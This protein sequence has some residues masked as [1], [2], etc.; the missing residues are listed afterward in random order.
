MLSIRRTIS[1]VACA[2]AIL[3]SVGV[4]LVFNLNAKSISVKTTLQ[5]L[6][7]EAEVISEY[8]LERHN[9]ISKNVTFLAKT[10]IA[11]HLLD[12]QNSPSQGQPQTGG[13]VL[14]QAHWRDDTADLFRTMI[15]VSPEYTQVRLIGT[16]NGGRE[17]VRVDRTSDG[18]IKRIPDVEL[19]DKSAEEYYLQIS[20]YDWSGLDPKKSKVLFSRVTFNRENGVKSYPLSYVVRAMHPVFDEADSL[21]GF[22]VINIDY[23][24]LLKS[25]FGG[26][27]RAAN[28]AVLN[29]QGDYIVLMAEGYVSELQIAGEYTEHPAPLLKALLE[30]KIEHGAMRQ[31]EEIS[32]FNRIAISPAQPD[33]W[34]NIAMVQPMSAVT[35]LAKGVGR[36]VLL[37][38]GLITLAAAL[39]LVVALS[40]LMRPMKLLREQVLRAYENGGRLHFPTHWK[41][42][43]GQLARAFQGTIDR[44]LRTETELNLI[45]DNIGEGI[46]SIEETGEISSFNAACETIFGYEAREVIGQ[47]IN[48][49]MPPNHAANHDRYLFNYARSGER[50]IK[51]EGRIEIGRR[52]GGTDFPMELTVTEIS[53]GGKRRFIGILRD[54]SNRLD[55]TRVG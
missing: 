54:V 28:V 36:Q 23:D 4:G 39:M 30:T 5:S 11:Q 29:D 20:D 37:S 1:I 18:E 9:S 50:R 40:A 12:A 34:I 27:H 22:V 31:D 44:H 43:V 48:I 21:M 51:W 10:K 8:F 53:L 14:D 55:R 46:V 38:V 26:V 19:Q 32:Y 13:A 24:K 52:K 2:T 3:T 35:D 16:R 17:M 45:L 15:E 41:N 25:A 6:K 33:R 7:S 47:K 42:E 49:L